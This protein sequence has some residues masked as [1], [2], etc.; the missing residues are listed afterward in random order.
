MSL[1]FIRFI[2]FHWIALDFTNCSH[3]HHSHSVFR[4]STSPW[5]WHPARNW[6]HFGQPW[7]S[8]PWGNKQAS[9]FSGAKHTAW[10]NRWGVSGARATLKSTKM[11]YPSRGKQGNPRKNR[12]RGPISNAFSRSM[13]KLKC[14]SVAF[15][16]LL[17][18]SF[19]ASCDVV[20]YVFC[21]TANIWRTRSGNVCSCSH[22]H[23][24]VTMMFDSDHIQLCFTRETNHDSSHEPW[25]T[26]ELPRTATSGHDR[27]R[28]L[29]LNAQR[30]LGCQQ[31]QAIGL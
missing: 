3:S 2:R 18:G 1:D 21:P 10:A 19:G 15:T 29:A 26:H 13:E 23:H 31:L 11:I 16:K 9:I 14:I 24:H 28:G 17:G 6:L 20:W 8:S 22:H 25:V 7:Q 27:W 5:W 12:E 30:F 4:S